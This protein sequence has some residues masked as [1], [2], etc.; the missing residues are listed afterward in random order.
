MRLVVVVP[1]YAA[2]A[3]SSS[4]GPCPPREAAS[5]F[6]V[7]GLALA[8]ER[9]AAARECEEPDRNERCLGFLHAE[10]FAALS[11]RGVNGS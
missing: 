10:S 9:G 4:P 2:A 3:S 8:C 7:G 11:K 5:T 1:R 6:F